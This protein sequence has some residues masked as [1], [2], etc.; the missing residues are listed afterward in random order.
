MLLSEVLSVT[1]PKVVLKTLKVWHVRNTPTIGKLVIAKRD[2]TVDRGTML[3]R[4][5]ELSPDDHEALLDGKTIKLPTKGFSSW[6]E[7]VEVAKQFAH[8]SGSSHGVVIQ[9]PAD[10]LNIWLDVDQFLFNHKFQ[11]LERADER[12][13]IVKDVQLSITK[14]DLYDK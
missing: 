13:I 3:Y 8:G 12:E 14:D 2:R 11:P 6:S 10:K 7:D 1:D 5:I 9:M 4:G